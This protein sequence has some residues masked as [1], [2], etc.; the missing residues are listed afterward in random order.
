VALPQGRLFFGTHVYI[1]FALWYNT[2]DKL[3]LSYRLR[4]RADARRRGNAM[5]VLKKREQQI[6]EYMKEE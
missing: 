5:E 6:L 3:R 4:T 1:L 2:S